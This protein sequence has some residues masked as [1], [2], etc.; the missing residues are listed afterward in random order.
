LQDYEMEVFGMNASPTPVFTTS[1]GLAF[2]F[3]FPN[4]TQAAVSP[5]TFCQLSSNPHL[6]LGA[7]NFPSSG[8]FTFSATRQD[9]NPL[10]SMTA[11]TMDNSMDST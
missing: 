7:T 11:T 2:G 10:D 4:N 6:N 8:G 1:T 9:G 5:P 3:G